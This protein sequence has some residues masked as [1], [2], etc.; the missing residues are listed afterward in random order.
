MGIFDEPDLPP[1]HKTRFTQK[2]D[3]VRAEPNQG[4]VQR[5][6]GGGG[7]NGKG[8]AVTLLALTGGLSALAYVVTE[9]GRTVTG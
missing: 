1:G 4:Q 8:C 9:L 7:S 6:G 3:Q 5:S 2:L